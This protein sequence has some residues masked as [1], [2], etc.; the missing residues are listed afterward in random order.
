MFCHQIHTNGKIWPLIFSQCGQQIDK[1]ILGFKWQSL[2]SLPIGQN[3]MIQS[4]FILQWIGIWLSSV[5]EA[6]LYRSDALSSFDQSKNASYWL[7][8]LIMAKTANILVSCLLQHIINK[9]IT[10]HRL[11]IQKSDKVHCSWHPHRHSLT[12]WD[13]DQHI[14]EG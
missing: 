2:N 8:L 5:E 6:N 11:I 10:I 12:M 9:R 7:K 4:A 1:L 14:R 3:I 13:I